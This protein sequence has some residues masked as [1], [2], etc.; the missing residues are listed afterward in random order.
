MIVEGDLPMLS[1]WWYLWEA[2]SLHWTSSSAPSLTWVMPR[3][4]KLATQWPR[5]SANNA[6]TR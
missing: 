5:T 6:F 1:T 2:S 4:S 3:G